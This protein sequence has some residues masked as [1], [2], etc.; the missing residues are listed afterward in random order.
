MNRPNRRRRGSMGAAMRRQEH[1]PLSL[2]QG[3]QRPALRGPGAEVLR[4]TGYP[5]IRQVL[6]DL[7]RRSRCPSEIDF[8]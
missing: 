8:G 1:E 3:L 7:G 4:P 5:V 2:P 6:A